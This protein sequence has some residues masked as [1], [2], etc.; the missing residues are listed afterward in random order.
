LRLLTL[1]ITG[2]NK[3]VAEY[4][5]ESKALK[6]EIFKICWYMRGGVT[7]AECLELIS[8]EDREIISKIVEKN[9]ETT[10]ESGL[11]FF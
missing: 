4:E 8:F 6:D 3:L 9:L 5:R 7:Y 2:I 11:P 1:D 10:K